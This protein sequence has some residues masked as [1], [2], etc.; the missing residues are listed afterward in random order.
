VDE[1]FRIVCKEPECLPVVKMHGFGV[2]GY[3]FLIRYPWFSVDS[4]SWT[5]VGSFGSFMVP[6]KRGGK[7][8]FGREPYVIA[9]SNDSPQNKVKGRHYTTLSKAEQR[10]VREWL[11]E[12][13]IPF[14]TSR[15]DEV[16][17]Y[18]VSNRH[19]ERKIANL[20]FFERLRAWLPMYPWPFKVSK[21]VGFAI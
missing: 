17:E 21:R 10:I 5:K 14:G 1:A 3:L 2:T 19:C 15:G 4:A 18:G 13:G 20:L 16:I 12:I 8:T 7:F 11:N 6:H 9:V